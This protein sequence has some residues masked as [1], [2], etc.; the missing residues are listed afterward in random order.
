MTLFRNTV[1]NNV[2]SNS[3]LHVIPVRFKHYIIKRQNY[4]FLFAV[5]YFK[6]LYVATLYINFSKRFPSLQ[7]YSF[8]RNQL[9]P[10]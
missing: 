10:S 6:N 4:S 8:L 2:I 5:L 1:E 7:V 3:S 9:F